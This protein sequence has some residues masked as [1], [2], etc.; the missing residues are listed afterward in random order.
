MKVLRS[1][2]II[3]F[4]SFFGF[5]SVLAQCITWND[6]PNKEEV[7]GNHSVYR[8]F[9]KNKSAD[10]LV[11]LDAQNFQIAF[12]AWKQVYEAA[13]AADGKRD[14]H[15]TDG[16]KI[17][18]A[19]FK[20]EADAAKK[21][22]YAQMAIDLYMKAAACIEN[23]TIEV[24]G[25]VD[26]YIGN[27]VYG[28]AGFDMYYIFNSLYS[29]TLEML[30]KAYEKAGNA[31]IYTLLE[32][33]ARIAA[34]QFDKELMNQADTRALYLKISDIADYNIE[35]NA[36]Y[37]EYYKSTKQ[38]MTAAFANVED[39]VF[40]CAYFKEKLEPSFRENPEDLEVLKYV[41]QKLRMQG[42]DSTDALL[43][44]VKVK[45]ETLAAE[46][47]KGLEE[48][49]RKD[50]PCYDAVQLQKEGKYEDALRRYKECLALPDD[51]EYAL[52]DNE[53]KAQIYYSM[54]NMECWQFGRLS[55]ARSNANKAASMRS[56]WGKPYILIGDIYSKMGRRACDDWN[57]RLAV[58][59][60]IE[61]YR[62]AKSIDSD[63][64]ADA[65]KRINNLSGSLPDKSEGF[66][67]KV[68][69]G[70]KVKVGCGIGETV[71]VRFK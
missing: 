54:A 32:P 30:N 8:Q 49:R 5:H 40:D 2:A 19:M 64:T 57:S 48:Q 55:A 20:K 18:T 58:L 41:Y 4:V 28:Q 46:I 12:D 42:C 10:D 22:E 66:M 45:Y 59:A 62:R 6:L 11:A 3:A 38:R 51:S 13:P 36:D 33:A 71:T 60:A 1:L 7:E 69:A 53:A 24:P 39:R 17:Y 68:S 14:W 25:N 23:G 56:G 63:A 47:N 50:N 31:T 15:F 70:Q 67:R 35:N 43:V 52:K 16:A 21:K 37:G 29:K 34:Y 9:L 61:K 26:E 65:N 27:Y 44:E